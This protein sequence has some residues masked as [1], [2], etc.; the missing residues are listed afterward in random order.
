MVKA[1]RQPDMNA[2]M[3]LSSLQSLTNGQLLRFG[4][5]T[6]MVNDHDVEVEVFQTQLPPR[7]LSLPREIRIRTTAM[8]V[9]LADSSINNLYFPHHCAVA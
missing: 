8:T 6:F 5:S 7:R 9:G 3:D 4:I 1:A 2:V